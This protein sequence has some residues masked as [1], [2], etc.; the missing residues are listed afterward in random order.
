LSSAQVAAQN[1][2]TQGS[3]EVLKTQQPP[4]HL[5]PARRLKMVLL[6]YMCPA[7]LLH[8]DYAGPSVAATQPLAGVMH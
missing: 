3:V 8:D 2:F 1:A 7:W 5:L 6:S 4:W